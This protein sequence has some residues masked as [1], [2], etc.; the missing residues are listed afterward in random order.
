MINFNKEYNSFATKH[1]GI[2]PLTLGRYQSHINKTMN[3][4]I[5]PTI[6]EERQ[7][8]IAQMDVFSRLLMDRILFLGTSIDDEVSNIIQSQLLFLESVDKEEDIQMYINSPGGSVVDGLGIYDVMQYINPDIST[9][10]TGLAASMASILLSAGTKGKRR[11]LKHGK[12]MI[13]QPM[14][15]MSG[16]VSEM[17]IYYNEIIKYQKELYQILAENTN[18]PYKVIEKDADRDH[19]LNAKEAMEYGI[20]DDILTKS[21]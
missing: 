12:I 7:M 21:K 3:Y 15:G 14:G 4:S 1:L 19:W 13:H 17:K 8:N 2:N 18:K 10:C 20:I 9:I 11:S 5:N 16:Q 6:I